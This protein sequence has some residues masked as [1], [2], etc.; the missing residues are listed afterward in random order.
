MDGEI[1]ST[2]CINLYNLTFGLSCYLSVENATSVKNGYNSIFK[3]IKKPAYKNLFN[4]K[5]N[6]FLA[7]NTTIFYERV[8]ELTS[9][10]AE[11]KTAYNYTI[12]KLA[13]RFICN[14]VFDFLK[15]EGVIFDNSYLNFND[16]EKKIEN[17][18]LKIINIL[19]DELIT[20]Y[21]DETVA[22]IFRNKTKASKLKKAVLAKIN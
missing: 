6:Q 22:N 14:L 3:D 4:N 15:S 20:N 2:N 11:N 8:R 9:K 19:K 17:Y 16:Y 7:W 18:V 12:P 1:V 10:I 21:K 5:V 13:D